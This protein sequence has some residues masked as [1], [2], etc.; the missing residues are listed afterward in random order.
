[1]K[2]IQI[3]NLYNKQH[4]VLDKRAYY[5]DQRNTRKSMFVLN[6]YYLFTTADL[7]EK[8]LIAD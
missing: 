4:T 5:E 3:I 2:E 6:Y 1:M 7:D 8:S